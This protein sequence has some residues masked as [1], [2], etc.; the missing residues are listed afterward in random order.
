MKSLFDNYVSL[1]VYVI[2]IFGITS[3]SIMEMQIINARHIHTAVV[4]QIQDSY[5]QVD[6]NKLNEKLHESFP[7]WNITSEIIK[8]N[9]DREDRLITLDYEVFL[10]V[11]SITKAGRIEGYAR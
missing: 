2:I 8:G 6:I 1:I 4:N 9:G 5:Y 11:F 3:F 7:S 10:P